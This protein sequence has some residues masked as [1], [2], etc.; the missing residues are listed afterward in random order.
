MN[1]VNARSNWRGLLVAAGSF[2]LYALVARGRDW[3]VSSWAL[4]ALICAF[5]G[6][7]FAVSDA[8]RRRRAAA[9]EGYADNS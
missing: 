9:A 1:L 2:I 6:G 8:R 4:A 7:V 5:V 3:D